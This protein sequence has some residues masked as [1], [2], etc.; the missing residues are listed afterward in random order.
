M[1]SLKIIQDDRNR[2]VWFRVRKEAL[3]LYTNVRF[4]VV[5]VTKAKLPDRGGQSR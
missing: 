4:S 3:L 5:N 2:A 1:N